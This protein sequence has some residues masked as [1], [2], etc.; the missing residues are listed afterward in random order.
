MFLMFMRVLF[1]CTSSV[2]YIVVNIIGNIVGA[3]IFGYGKGKVVI[4]PNV[5]RERCAVEERFV[6]L[7]HSCNQRGHTS[8]Y[9]K[10]G[11]THLPQK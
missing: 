8:I 7:Q 9:I 4:H 11:R 6:L 3:N 10:R 1:V 2:T 5:A